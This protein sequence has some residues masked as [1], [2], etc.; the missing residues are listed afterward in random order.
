M[1]FSFQKT[2]NGKN[3]TSEGKENVKPTSSKRQD[4]QPLGSPDR[5]TPDIPVDW[6]QR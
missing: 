1:M 6:N 2:T 4:T 3:Y 5:I